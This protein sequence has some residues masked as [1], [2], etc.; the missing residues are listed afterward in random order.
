VG[1]FGCGF[2]CVCVCVWVCLCVCMSVWVWVCVGVGV[3][4]CVCLC[5]CVASVDSVIQ[6]S[7]E[8]TLVHTFTENL[9]LSLLTLDITGTVV[10]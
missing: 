3:S 6:P 1:V 5:V 2:L 8:L 7:Q 10:L 9:T 4:V